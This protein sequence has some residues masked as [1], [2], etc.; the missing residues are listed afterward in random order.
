MTLL[1]SSSSNRL[2][3]FLLFLLITTISIYSAE[4][5]IKWTSTSTQTYTSPVVDNSTVYSVSASGK[6][7]ALA[8]DTGIRRYS[9]ELGIPVSVTPVLH[10]QML[11]IATDTGIQAVRK[12]D[13]GQKVSYSTQSPV[14]TQPLVFSDNVLIAI[15]KDGNIHVL[16]IG[17]QSKIKLIRT[18]LLPAQSEASAAVYGG[19]VFV[20]LTDGR[21]YSVDP[22]S[23]TSVLL[24]DTGRSIWRS[25]PAVVNDILYVGADRYLMAISTT[26]AINFSKELGGQLYSP[27]VS[28]DKIF[29]GSNDENLY[30]LNLFGDI[31]WKFKAG[32][33]VRATPLVI[34][35]T[36]YIGSNDRKMY[37]LD[38][39]SGVV[40]WSKSV[41]DWPSSAVYSN[42]LV[43]TSTYNGTT[44]AISTIS[45]RVTFP[46]Q[47]ATIFARA[48]LAG[49][50][51]AD[52]GVGKVEVR[53]FP[54]DFESTSG[55]AEW[56]TVL[57]I[58]G[59]S[60]G[61]LTIQCRVADRAGNSEIEPYTE[62]IYNYVFSEEK[63]PKINVTAPKSVT[64]NS[65]FTIQFKDAAGKPL[66]NISVTIEGKKYT[67]ADPTG[68]FTF[69]PPR[70]GP[71]TL[72]IEKP[73]Y[74]TKTVS[75]QVQK[76]YTV[77][78]VVG[79]VVLVA[80]I[81]Y[82]FGFRRGKWR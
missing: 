29:I 40:K 77:E 82:F 56:S 7:V 21:L 63:L 11:Y 46:E 23:G 33:A 59:A 68:L 19:R 26:G 8:K 55:L 44:T 66:T 41:D 32:D 54:G 30:A 74:Q 16:D 60:E 75:I 62:M 72:F 79:F 34:N 51:Y 43:Y 27:V 69:I 45:C 50:A 52:A 47:N 73:N 17:D 4:V 5:D 3:S 49:Q 9:V 14:L 25:M 48:S 57:P 31:L 71:L 6:L 70:E 18:I 2:L 22:Q 37:A 81:I 80:L 36:V 38:I 10:N 61:Q 65:A 24:I 20:F 76:S 58:V 67:V 1:S 13:G 35:N 39:S 64:V 15:T 78:I 42:G 12:S 28:Q 53:T